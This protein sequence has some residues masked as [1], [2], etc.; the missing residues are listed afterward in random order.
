MKVYKSTNLVY[1]LGYNVTYRF[2]IFSYFRILPG[3]K[4]QILAI[5]H[6][7]L[8]FFSVFEKYKS[9]LI[10]R[11]RALE[12]PKIGIHSL[13]GGVSKL[14]LQ[15]NIFSFFGLYGMSKLQIWPFLAKN[16]LKFDF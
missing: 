2:F 12:V 14:D 8:A 10:A 15:N 5:F 7:F 16:G 1:L 13:C 3:V 4:F 11:S 9:H 6:N